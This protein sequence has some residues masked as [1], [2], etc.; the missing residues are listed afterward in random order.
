MRTASKIEPAGR[1]ERIIV[2][3]RDPTIAVIAQLSAVTKPVARRSSCRKACH[4]PDRECEE[5]RFKRRAGTTTILI[6]R[7]RGHGERR[8]KPAKQRSSVD[9]LL[10]FHTGRKA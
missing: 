5:S 1:V 4:F 9:H 3:H 6:P 8:S 2:R 10:S 7:P